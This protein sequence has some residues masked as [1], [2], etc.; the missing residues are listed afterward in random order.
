M[1]PKKCSKRLAPAMILIALCLIGCS[2]VQKSTQSTFVDPETENQPGLAIKLAVGTLNLEETDHAVTPEQAAELL[3]L[4][5]AY[6]WL[7]RS[8][9]TSI[10]ELDALAGQI[11]EA[12]TLDQVEA[13]NGLDLE[14]P[15]VEAMMKELGAASKEKPAGLGDSVK[16]GKQPGGKGGAQVSG[17]K[18]GA[19]V[20][21][22]KLQAMKSLQ[23]GGTS[24]WS[25]MAIL[26]DAVIKVLESKL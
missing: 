13:I 21:T 1:I 7:S 6:Q 15:A 3:P 22:E 12:M 9:T 16:G 26:V 11:Q 4:W 8:D 25:T 17:G 2:V 5:E 14:A 10:V 24:D 19:Q 23:A 20:S 18:G